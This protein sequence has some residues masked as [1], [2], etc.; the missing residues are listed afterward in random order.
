MAS[1]GSHEIQIA[2]RD[3]FLDSEFDRPVFDENAS[4]AEA[5]AVGGSGC[6]VYRSKV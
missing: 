1:R 2:L 3:A 6:N 4:D 5:F